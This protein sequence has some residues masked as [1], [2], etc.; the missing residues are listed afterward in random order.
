MARLVSKCSKSS[1]QGLSES[2]Q[3]FLSVFGI[4]V[5]FLKMEFSAGNISLQLSS[6]FFLYETSLGGFFLFFYL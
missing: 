3:N 5:S 4:N 1:Y 6:F 2:L